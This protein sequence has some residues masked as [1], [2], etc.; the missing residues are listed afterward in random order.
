MTN[1]RTFLTTTAAATVTTLAA[2]P[3]GAAAATGTTGKATGATGAK[4]GRGA[5]GAT[6]ASAHKSPDI[7]ATVPDGLNPV[8]VRTAGVR[9]V[10]VVG[11]KYKVWTKRVGNGAT[12]VLLLHGGPAFSHEYLEAIAAFLP[13]AGYEIYFYDQLGVNN[14][15]QPDDTSLWTVPRYLEEVE[16]V[17][18]ALGLDQFVLFGHSWGGVLAIEYALKHP[19]ALKGLVISNMV[20]GMQAYLQRINHLKTTLLPAPLLARVNALENAQDYE[21]PEYEQIVMEHLY[22]KVICRLDPWPDALMRSFKHL[23]KSIY[24][25]MQGPSEFQVSGSLK[26]WERWDRLHEIRTR[27]LILGATH[28]TMDPED[29]KRMA[30]LMPNAQAAICPNGSHLSMWDDQAAYFGHLLRFLATV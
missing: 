19:L 25:Q 2:A 4:G 20:A 5:T 30:R 14:S 26:D 6:A 24:V 23:N 12:K 22:A 10:P 29:I 8:G 1:R 13:E 11:G 28:D 9:L 16:E 3:M 18:R 21:N 7:A 27:T 15:D 17:R